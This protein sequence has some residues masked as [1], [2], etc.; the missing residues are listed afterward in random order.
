L[1][2]CRYEAIAAPQLAERTLQIPVVAATTGAP[3][4]L[5]ATYYP[6][7]HRNA[8]RQPPVV[9]F[10]PVFWSRGILHRGREGGLIPFLNYSGFPVWLVY[11]DQYEGR[12]PRELGEALATALRELAKASDVGQVFL[13]GLSL[14]SQAVLEAL[15]QASPEGRLGRVLVRKVFF[16]GAGLDYAFPDSFLAH[17]QSLANGPSKALCDR[18]GGR[19]CQRY[20]SGGQAAQRLLGTLPL[21]DTGPLDDARLP[22]L[23]S[24]RMPALFVA[25]KI[26]GIAP[27]ESVFPAYQRYGSREPD[28]RQIPKRLLIAGLENRMHEDY[29]HY[30][31]FAGK[32]VEGDVF[33]PLRQWLLEPM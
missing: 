31:L 21:L 26:D 6:L 14:G 8:R 20:F 23:A 28:E 10:D 19:A 33:E 1:A 15:R 18:D 22:S 29:D 30:T 17:S 13:G 27:S 4:S 12:T 7:T 3:V 16:I 25:G 2:G 11:A 24:F 9:L 32:H 5:R